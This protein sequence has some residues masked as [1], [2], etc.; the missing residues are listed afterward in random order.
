MSDK[1]PP[2]KK[3]KHDVVAHAEGSETENKLSRLQRIITG[4]RSKAMKIKRTGQSVKKTERQ[5]RVRISGKLALMLQ[6][7]FD[8]FCEIAGHLSPLDLLHLARSTRP[9]R[10]MLMSKSARQI[11]CTS[12]S[13]LDIPECPSDINEP[14]L[15]SLIFENFCQGCGAPRVNKV[16]YGLRVRLCAGCFTLNVVRGTKLVEEVDSTFCKDYNIYRLCYFNGGYIIVQY[17]LCLPDS[18][19]AKQRFFRPDF[20]DTLRQYLS[21]DPG[22]DGQKSFIEKRKQLVEEICMHGLAIEKWLMQNADK[23]HK[24][25]ASKTRSRRDSIFTRLRG[26]GYTDTD[27]NSDIDNREWKWI[28]LVYQPRELTERIWKSI[29]PQLETTIRLRREKRTQLAL[30]RRYKEREA[31]L[32][33]FYKNICDDWEIRVGRFSALTFNEF[34]L[35]PGVRELIEKDEGT[36]SITKNQWDKIEQM[37]YDAI[38]QQE[39]RIEKD[40][41]AFIVSAWEEAG[42]KSLIERSSGATDK[43]I[44]HASAFLSSVPRYGRALVTYKE[45]VAARA[46]PGCTRT[47][48]S[49]LPPNPRV[50]KYANELIRSLGMHDMT[51]MDKMEEMGAVFVCKC[52]DP[53]FHRKMTWKDLVIHFCIEEDWLSNAKHCFDFIRSKK[54]ECHVV[55]IDDHDIADREDLAEI[56]HEDLPESPSHEEASYICAL[57]KSISIWKYFDLRTH[58]EAHV[59]ARH[60]KTIVEQADIKILD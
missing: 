18:T 11:W 43:I 40:C 39:C 9:L 28:S 15:A 47:W 33:P 19:F 51:T 22:S 38:R 54:P 48:P 42:L 2:H 57:C 30:E 29:Q 1:Q 60:G 50:T 41:T 55:L 27:L 4:E 25:E 5:S 52:C 21:Y 26:M 32:A 56:V 46:T 35:L 49:H 44:Y 7:P 31:E 45:L 24:D 37:V 3:A 14:Q 34:I 58:A 13:A 53:I 17:P 36:V 8:V 23:K 6:M 10:D 20:S 16:D 59:R 12:L